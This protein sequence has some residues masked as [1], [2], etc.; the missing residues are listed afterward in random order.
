MDVVRFN[1]ARIEF[2][3][4][5]LESKGSK[6]GSKRLK[7]KEQGIVAAADA[8]VD[9]EE[10]VVAGAQTCSFAEGS[11]CNLGHTGGSAV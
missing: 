5:V 2:E 3:P 9:E 1:G 10:N 8:K 6:R 4:S 7:T 11:V